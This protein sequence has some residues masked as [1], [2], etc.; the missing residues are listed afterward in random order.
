[1]FL[2]FSA[3]SP[4]FS[5][6]IVG[7]SIIH[8][9]GTGALVAFLVGGVAAAVLALLYA[10]VGAA[11]PGAGG[12]YPSLAALLGPLTAFPYIIL[13]APIAIAGTAYSALGFADYIR[14]LAPG[15]P[16]MPIA[17]ASLL[18][19]TGI[20]V[21][22]IRAG[23]L[24]T[25]VFLA[26]ETIAVVLLSGVALFHPARPIGQ[27]L[28]HPVM[29]QHGAMVAT[30]LATLGLATVS[31]IYACGGGSWAMYFAE[32]M[33]DAR[34][35]IGRVIAWTGVIA[36]LAIAAPVILMLLSARDL[37]SVLASDTPVATFLAQTGGPLVAAV[38]SAGVAAA[39]FNAL[40]A[41][42]MA[43]SRYVYATGRDGIWP[44]PVNRLLSALHPGFRTPVTATLLLAAAA[45]AACFLGEKPLVILISGN[46]SD[47]ILISIAIIVGRRRGVVGR[48][49]R[50]PLHPMVPFFGLTVAGLSIIADWM[51][52]DAGR[53]SMFLLVGLFFGA[54][55]YYHFRLRQVSKTWQVGGAALEVPELAE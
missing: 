15:L 14:V 29:L 43:Y 37:T 9:G 34:R 51:D 19:G 21:L 48:D 40:V 46:V 8:I 24:V 5:V 12:I 1:M 30:P 55:A 10:E 44:A 7:D 54:L 50:A 41:T 38:V 16:P 23:A 45:A 53:P 47:Y 3:L 52:P 39:V 35:T 27:V 26:I 22:N 42:V 18:L 2:T 32:E 13:V 49:F 25:G 17:L 36:S 20:A 4:A 31:G 33:R 28:A 11:F 6:Y